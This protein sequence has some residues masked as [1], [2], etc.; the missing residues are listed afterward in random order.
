MFSV[1]RNATVGAATL[2][3]AAGVSVPVQAAYTV[4]LVQQGPN[5]VANGSGSIDLT[6]LGS[7][8]FNIGFFSHLIAADG[9]INTG[10]VSNV[11]EYSGLTGPTS[12]G[13]GGDQDAV[14][15]S[16]ALVGVSGIEADLIVPA[17][18]VS[19]LPLSDSA[20][21]DNATFA[22]LGVTPG[23]YVWTWGTGA[24]ADSFTLDIMAAAAA[25]E[26]ASLAL[27][28][29]GLAGLGIVLRTRRA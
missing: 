7:P 15:G 2:A 29:I 27:F 21:Y 12:F 24:N 3:L 28:G 19:D 11:D 16:G 17:G 1:F 20:T 10:P 8:I 13:S 26:P 14:G 18:Y 23:T 6:G 4:T 9:V 22:S 25:P 5:V